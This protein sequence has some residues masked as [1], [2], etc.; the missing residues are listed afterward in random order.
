MYSVER[1]ARNLSREGSRQFLKKSAQKIFGLR[2]NCTLLALAK[3]AIT[4][5][6]GE[7]FLSIS[8]FLVTHRK[9][10]ES[11]N[12]KDEKH[13]AQNILNEHQN[14]YI[15]ASREAGGGGGRGTGQKCTGS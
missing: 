9:H 11:D 14:H 12:P 2:T 8:P 10:S 4:K 13:S 5:N 6:L 7:R 3:N 15:W 1:V